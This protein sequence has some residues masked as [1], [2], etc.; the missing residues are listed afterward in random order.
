M[1]LVAEQCFHVAPAMHH[2]KNQHIFA[3]DAVYDDVLSDGKAARVFTEVFT[4]DFAQCT[5]GP[6]EERIGP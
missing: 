5:G 2:A 4:G 6:Q 3:L 1:T